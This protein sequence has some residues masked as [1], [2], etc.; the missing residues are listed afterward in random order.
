M[1]WSKIF[2][3]SA[4]QTIDIPEDFLHNRSKDK[5]NNMGGIPMKKVI[6]IIVLVLV[7]A[8][9]ITL[10]VLSKRVKWNDENAPGNTSGNLLNG[11][12][13]CEYDDFSLWLI[14]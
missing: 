14:F 4:P 6:T 12:E 7:I 10:S 3:Q 5:N 2:S 9:A 13:F 1:T 8:G 11:G